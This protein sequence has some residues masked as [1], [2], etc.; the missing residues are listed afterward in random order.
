MKNE[1]KATGIV[2]TMEDS[3]S[4]S[5][6]KLAILTRGVSDA[7][8]RARCRF[9]RPG[10][11]LDHA[12]LHELDSGLRVIEQHLMFW[13]PVSSSWQDDQ[14]ARLFETLSLNTDWLSSIEE[15]SRNFS[16]DVGDG[17]AVDVIVRVG[18]LVAVPVPVG[19]C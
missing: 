1:S 18:E 11:R 6:L 13:F 14:W 3:V 19:D 4:G 9:C 15:R 8:D 16:D 2:V 17:V 5:K 12:L 10:D 7:C